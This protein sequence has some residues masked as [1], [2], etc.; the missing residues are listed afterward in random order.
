MEP[1]HL[2]HR[3][4]GMTEVCK[5][6]SI[7]G[8]KRITGLCSMEMLRETARTMRDSCSIC[9]TP[10]RPVGQCI[11][12]DGCADFPVWESFLLRLNT[13]LSEP[14]HVDDVTIDQTTLD[15]FGRVYTNIAH[16]Y[17]K[18]PSASDIEQ[19]VTLQYRSPCSWIYE[20]YTYRFYRVTVVTNSTT[21]YVESVEYTD[22]PEAEVA[23]PGFVQPYTCTTP[24]VVYFRQGGWAVGSQWC[25]STY[26]GW[27]WVFRLFQNG[28]VG[29]PIARLTLERF[30]A[31][32]CT[33]YIGQFT[34]PIHTPGTLHQVTTAYT[35]YR[36]SFTGTFEVPSSQIPKT[37]ITT[38]LTHQS[39]VPSDSGTN[40]QASYPPISYV[41]GVSTYVIGAT[42]VAWQVQSPS[43]CDMYNPLE[44]VKYGDTSVDP[45]FVPTNG[46]LNTPFGFP[47]IVLIPFGWSP[48]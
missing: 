9:L 8:D 11:G 15:V 12:V 39:T 6:W 40:T 19:N 24:T 7:A 36:G 38:G 43:L 13:T 18:Y 35:P 10:S 17:D 37:G 31:R 21:E 22:V 20:N 3:K 1:F 33:Q 26:W 2:L 30:N 42:I 34:G 32:H 48:P 14:T 44:L 28:G 41:I 16:I 27:R 5:T 4:K 29:D 23:A 25:S 45:W 47:D 46:P